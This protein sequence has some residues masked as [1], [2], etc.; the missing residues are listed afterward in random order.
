MDLE[1]PKRGRPEKKRSEK[2]VERVTVNVT[3]AGEQVIRQEASRCRTSLARIFDC[4][5]LEEL[6]PQGRGLSRRHTYVF[7]RSKIGDIRR[8]AERQEEEVFRMGM[9][10]LASEMK[11]KEERLKRL[12]KKRQQLWPK[13]QSNGVSERLNW[14]VTPDRKQW[15]E[16]R[17]DREGTSMSFLV[18]AAALQGIRKREDFGKG[19]EWLQTWK[20]ELRTASDDTSQGVQRARRVADDIEAKLKA[21]IFDLSE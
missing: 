9:G 5:A 16:R 2:K 11:I 17:A 19:I 12:R 3:E 13:V 18:R 10:K 20:K 8:K 6:E 4:I 15:V 14:A 1:P 21:E 7:L